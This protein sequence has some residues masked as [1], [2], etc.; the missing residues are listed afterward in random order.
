MTAIPPRGPLGIELAGIIRRDRARRTR[1]KRFGKFLG[2][3]LA[4]LLAAFLHALL[5][6]WAFM[7]A[8]DVANDHWAPQLPSIGFWWAVLVAWLLR[9]ALTPRQ[10]VDSERTS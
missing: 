8:V 7:L 5:A 2:K 9:S 3:F 10:P 4:N 1:G 6:G